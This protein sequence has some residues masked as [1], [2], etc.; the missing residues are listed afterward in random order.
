MFTTRFTL[1][2]LVVAS[3]LG[4]AIICESTVASAEIPLTPAQEPS[5]SNPVDLNCGNPSYPTH[6]LPCLI[7]GSASLSAR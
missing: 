7:T 6:I 4:A 5:T 2:G 3:A 1:R